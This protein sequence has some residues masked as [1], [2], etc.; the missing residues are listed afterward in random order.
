MPLFSW[1]E[2]VILLVLVV[3]SAALFWWR[4][5]HVLSVISGSR[6][7]PDF[8]LKPIARRV[9]QFFWEVLLQGKV[10]RQ[11]PLPGI[12][13]ALVFWGF[14]AFALVSMNHFAEGL[15]VGFLDKDS[16]LGGFYFAFAGLFAIGVSVGILGLA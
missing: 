9:R 14:C 15:G 11:R 4:L 3:T 2:R 12:A 6:P 8:S 5:R 7:T 16:W 10:I 1:T 13:H